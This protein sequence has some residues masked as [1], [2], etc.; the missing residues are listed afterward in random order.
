MN[1][2]RHLHWWS[3]S[4]SRVRI[5]PG[6][7][8]RLS[9]IVAVLALPVAFVLWHF[10]PFRAE[11]AQTDTSTITGQVEDDQGMPVAEV[12]VTLSRQDF[13]A[14]ILTEQD[15]K[16]EFRKLAMGSYTLIA[17]VAGFRKEIVPLIIGRPG[18]ALTPV[19][20]LRPSSLHVAVFDAATRQPLQGVAVVLSDREHPASSPAGRIVTDEAGDAFFGRLGSGSYQL[21]ASHRG[22]DEYRSV[23]FISSGKITTEF[24]LPL[25]IAP[26]IP[27]NDKASQRYNVPNLPSKN[28][29]ALFQDT[30]GWLWIGTDKG[31]ARF[32]GADFKSS[33]ASGSSYAAFAGADVRSITEDQRGLIWLGTGRGVERITKD[34]ASEGELLSGYD[35]RCVMPD[36]RGNVWVA[37]GAGEFKFD[38]NGLMTPFDTSRGLASTDVRGTTLYPNGTVLIATAV[39]AYAVNGDNAVPVDLAPYIRQGAAVHESA[40]GAVEPEGRKQPTN[41]PRAVEGASHT[42]SGKADDVR[43]VFV[44]REGAAWFATGAGVVSINGNKDRGGPTDSSSSSGTLAVRDGGVRAISQ[45]GAGRLSFALN[46]DGALIYSANRHESQRIA[47]VERDRVGAILADQEGNVWFG[48]D[49]GVLRTDFY[50]FVEFN[51]SRGMAD[52]D[53]REIIE[54]PPNFA[55]PRGDRGRLWFLTGTGISVMENEKLAPLEG[56]RASVGT[57]SIAFDSQGAAWIGTDQGVFKLGGQAL[58]QLNEGNGLASNKVNCVS[59]IDNSVV[60]LATT[61][62]LDL[63]REGVLVNADPVSGYDVRYVTLGPGGGLWCATDRGI[64]IFDLATGGAEVIDAGRGLIDDDVRC[65]ARSGDRMVVATRSGVQYFDTTSAPAGPGQMS[66]GTIDNEAASTL[67]LDRDG[68]LW[69]GTDDGQVKKYAYSDGQLISTAYSAETAAL[70]N[71]RINSIYEDGMGRIWIATTGGAVR[72]MPDRR[73]PMTQV[74]AE[75]DGRP[76]QYQDAAAQEAEVFDVP[77]GARKLTFYFTGVSMDGPVRFLYR[78]KS[79]SDDTPWTILPAQQ[80]AERE[81]SISDFGRGPHTFEIKAINRDLYGTQS[82]A[83]LLSLRVGPPFWQKGWFYWLAV[84]TA[85]LAAGAIVAARRIKN[86]EFVLPRELRSYLPIE[87]NPYIVGNPIRTESMFYGREDDFRYVR[88]KLES[89]NQGVV[90]VF[91]GERR[92]GKSSILYQVLNGRL[93]S[94]FV[95]VFVDMQEM[96]IASDSEFFSRTSRLIAESIVNAD[97]ALAVA[98]AADG[99][100]TRAHPRLPVVDKHPVGVSVP[101]FTGS[102]PYPVFLDFLDDVL[103]TLGG[104]TLLILVDEYELMESKVDDGKLSHEIFTFLAGLMDNKEHLALIFTGSRRLEERDKKYWRELLRRSLFRKVGF[105]SEKD[106]VRLI[107]EPVA[108]RV[109]YGRGVIDLICRLT[110]GQPFYTQVICQNTVDCLN[111]EKRNW[112]VT[113]DLMRVVDDIVDNPLPQMIYTWDGLSDD[114]KIALSLLAES[115]PDGSMYV[116]AAQLRASIELRKYPVH[117]S[118]NTIRLTL[119]EVFRREMLDKDAANGFRFKIDLLRLWV[120]RSHSIWQVINE[121]RTL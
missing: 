65:L 47:M 77:Y 12:K 72:H 106:A 48:T 19:I 95:P 56:F 118:E 97:S 61:R 43:A 112:V 114:E 75:V 38:S 74:S 89:A 69:V 78:L 81:V 25:S 6:S 111:E 44:D 45:D 117:L 110:A 60:A 15:G 23:V 66:T 14:S 50:S 8:K 63:Y 68:Y 104:R 85:T 3:P 113:S 17:E 49:D 24:A 108:G 4:V 80:A 70:T 7:T 35:V 92:V 87:P 9:R 90:I 54:E 86:R 59:V 18:E 91:C 32:N 96:V 42:E 37:T 109:V 107:I 79:G 99:P 119:E 76:M 115:L 94:R 20:K 102:N 36:T 21:A 5:I 53:V 2:F 84:L 101:S 30:E 31:I 34:G 40:S 103:K 64:V 73:T 29:Q 27:I 62:G 28:V 120:R 46:T 51:T 71:N 13:S 67:F 58:T 1:P 98:A 16:F 100:S 57:R 41:R 93:G 105:L 52:N 11:A 88:T 26:L 82:T 121:V 55:A 116:T 22:Y 33:A 39:G 83:A 10:S